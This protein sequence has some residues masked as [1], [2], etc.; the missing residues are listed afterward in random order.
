MDATRALIVLLGAALAGCSAAPAAVEPRAF[1]HPVSAQDA[2]LLE[3]LA[4]A[5]RDKVPPSVLEIALPSYFLAMSCRYH[6]SKVSGVT[7]VPSAKSRFLPMTLAL[8]ARRRRWL[9]V[10]KM[11]PVPICSRSTRVSACRYSMTSC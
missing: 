8:L 1:V 9:S 11:R 5:P 3:V 6:R 4:S 10:N 7:I 2:V